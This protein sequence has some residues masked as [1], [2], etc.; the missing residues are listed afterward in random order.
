MQY[1]VSLNDN[2]V[3]L[4][5]YLGAIMG[6]FGLLTFVADWLERRWPAE[7]GGKYTFTSL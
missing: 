3:L 7:Q 6:G 4:M 2:E 1:V 5:I